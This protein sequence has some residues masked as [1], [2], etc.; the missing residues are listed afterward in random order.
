[1][2]RQ[3]LACLSGFCDLILVGDQRSSDESRSI[4]REFSKVTLI[5]SHEPVICEQARWKLWDEARRLPGENLIW[6]TDADELVSPRLVRSCLQRHRDHLVPGTVVECEYYHSWSVPGRYRDDGSPY[7]PYWKPVAIVDDRRVDFGRDRALP[8]HEERVPVSDGSPTLR[9]AAV[10]I[11]HLQWLLPNRMQMR[12]AWYRCRELMDSG[13]PPADINRQYSIALPSSRQRTRQM[14]QHWIEDVS[15][16]D[17]SVDREP[18][19]QEAEILRWFD[20]R[21]PAYFEPLEIWHVASLR[22]V[23]RRMTGREPR[24]DRSYRPRWTE[25]AGRAARRIAGGARRRVRTA[26]G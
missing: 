11:L 3:S 10:P 4:V 15:F 17:L 13:R 26:L 5:E 18:P 22:E 16:P 25:R 1:V 14:P 24:P 12:Q 21:G 20:E 8:L 9:A 6:C 23:F 19:W 7:A 2:L